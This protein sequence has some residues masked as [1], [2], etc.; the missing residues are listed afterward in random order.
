LL[1]ILVKIRLNI[2]IRSLYRGN[3]RRRTSEKNFVEFN[4]F[5]RIENYQTTLSRP[6]E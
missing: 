6:I 5:R 4:A 2:S 3:K 1:G